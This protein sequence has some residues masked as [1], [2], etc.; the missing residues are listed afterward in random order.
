VPTAKELEYIEQ[1]ALDFQRLTLPRMAG[2]IF[3][4]LLISESP[5][6]TMGEL[7]EVLGASKGSISTMTRLL[8]QFGLVERASLPGDRRDRYRI[9]ADAW[10]NALAERLTQA[11]AFRGL[12]DRGLALLAGSPPD[13]RK[14]LEEMR[15]MYALL[16]GELPALLKRWRGRRQARNA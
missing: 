12:A 4:W 11:V 9:R 15:G 16:E 7:V 1:V 5:S 2:R 10:E 6:A 14:R 8:I 13:R 3:G